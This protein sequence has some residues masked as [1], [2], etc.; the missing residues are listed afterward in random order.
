MSE[1]GAGGAKSGGRRTGKKKK[2]KT[3]GWGQQRPRLMTA[4]I[5]GKAVPFSNT[6]PPHP[7]QPPRVSSF[8]MHV[9]IRAALLKPH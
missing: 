1:G 2:R 9:F 5:G 4:L 6:P 3:V 8:E 7:P